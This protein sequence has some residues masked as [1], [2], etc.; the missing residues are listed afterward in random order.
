VVSRAVAAVKT[1]AP[2]ADE[3][4]G[5]IMGIA[6]LRGGPHMPRKR[7][8]G[9][10]QTV[11]AALAI[12][13]IGGCASLPP[14][15]DFPKHAS[16]AI[17]HSET[18]RLGMSPLGEEHRKDGK[19]GF[20]IIPVGA[21]GFRMRMQMIQVAERT[22]DL[23]YFILHGDETGRLLTGAVLAAADRGVRV[24]ILVDDGETN[25]GDEQLTRLESHP[26]IELRIFNPFSYR[27]HWRAL[28]AM[29]FTA[30][31]SR[32]DYRMHN[33]LMVVDNAIALIG[34]RNIG[35]QYFQIDPDSQF[36]DD[37][38]FVF[39]PVV[40]KLSGT[41][42]EY[43]NCNL[44][45][46]AQ[47]LAGGKGSRAELAE[48]R[49]TL[50]SEAQQSKADGVDYLTGL[51]S[52][53]P[54]AGI[55]AG[56]LKLYWA[57]SEVICDS[58]NKRDVEAG[59]MVGRLMHRSVAKA[60]RNVQ[61]ELLMVTPYLVPGQEGMQLLKD[62]RTSNVRVRILTN[63][64]ESSTEILAQAVY[65]RYRGP[66]LESG[67]ELYE[68]RS[69]LG[70]SQGSG[71]ANSISRYGNYS[72]HAKMFV[73]DRKKVFLG[74]M[75][76]DQRSLH[77]NTEIGLLVESA[78]LAQQIAGRFDAMVQP[79]NSYQPVWEAAVGDRAGGL[80]WRTNE[81]A[82]PVEYRTEPA[83]SSLQRFEAHLL[84]WLPIDHEL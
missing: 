71:Q 35:D 75:N 27:G 70:N 11:I 2:S 61:N 20:R 33:K 34:G 81:G 76:F 24:R 67:V 80:V 45:I 83:R 69:L 73:F 13:L 82:E 22:V 26:L 51:A 52:G 55:M 47:A 9:H 30:E 78:E 12:A 14:G 84:S 62:L 63:S 40:Q 3:M 68:V 4:R 15:S 42:D 65:M 29:E 38:L 8:S 54:L 58:P 48:H 77:L 19:S 6:V 53:E 57:H 1:A 31:A 7:I 46:P 44:A 74:S 39:G 64:L 66:L 50:R 28:R 5:L 37:D 41:F 23:Q 36:A 25:P 21:D 49:Q 60:M 18:T 43:W 79:A 59:E 16:S 17:E 56:R 32:L 72:L 10:L